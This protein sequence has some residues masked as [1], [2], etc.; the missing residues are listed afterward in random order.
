M[1]CSES[2]ISGRSCR[3]PIRRPSELSASRVQRRVVSGSNFQQRSRTSWCSTPGAGASWGARRWPLCSPTRTPPG[4]AP[5]SPIRPQGSA[6]PGVAGLPAAVAC[7]ATRTTPS[8]PSV[9]THAAR[10][11]RNHAGSST[12]AQRSLTAPEPRR[13][14]RENCCLSWRSGGV[15][16]SPGG[17]ESR[18]LVAPASEFPG[19]CSDVT[20][21]STPCAGSA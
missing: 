16:V 9:S 17:T 11:V 20:L 18:C 1:R 3:T 13:P 4:R 14:L 21:S 5:S 6:A 2:A 8:C 19:G 15:A 12:A 10:D 7:C